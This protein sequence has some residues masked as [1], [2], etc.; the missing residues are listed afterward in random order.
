MRTARY[1]DYG[2]MRVLKFIITVAI[3]V[4]IGLLINRF[5]I[6][7]PCDHDS[8]G[9]WIT[10]DATCTEEGYQYRPCNDCGE[11]VSKTAIPAKGHEASGDVVPV[12]KPTCTEAGVGYL[13]CAA[14][15]ER[16]DDVVIPALGHN[17]GEVVIENEK[18]HNASMKGDYYE[19]VTYCTEC[20]IELS[21]DSVEE[22][23]E[24]TVSTDRLD[25]TCTTPG[26][27]NTI[28]Y[29]KDCN[30]EISNTDEP[31]EIIPHAFVWELTYDNGEYTLNGKCADCNH[32]Y[33]PDVDEG[34]AFTAY[35]DPNRSVKPTCVR[36]YNFHIAS[37]TLNG[38]K[39]GE[40]TTKEMLP[41]DPEIKH[42]I[43]IRVKD[44]EG[45]WLVMNR[46]D[47]ADYNIN[48][49][50]YLVDGEGKLINFL[51]FAQEDENGIYYNISTLGILKVENS[52]WD[53][54]GFALGTFKCTTNPD[55]H[56]FE[57]WITVRVYND[58]A[59]NDSAEDGSV[60]NDSS[61]SEIA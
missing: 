7:P 40:A 52:E 23:H 38:E 10:V 32:N 58:L 4:V 54:N 11:E 29:C 5:L 30:R 57:H 27:I 43:Y 42:S 39:I 48:A 2:L 33:D 53:E 22:E 26:N 60:E 21:R 61:E 55:G 36:G 56:E 15:G 34:Y 17:P 59:E 12:E 44:A 3:L 45:N 8:L 35:I 41:A 51:D 49:D 19:K 14:C 50:G 37:I 9:E 24:V 28:V 6:N 1:N 25:P 18:A 20:D 13:E 16:L 47:Y 46:D 31:I